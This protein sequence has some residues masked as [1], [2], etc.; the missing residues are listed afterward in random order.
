MPP[1]SVQNDLCLNLLPIPLFAPHNYIPLP[2]FPPVPPPMTG[3][4]AACHAFEIPVT[5]WWPPGYAL[6]GAAFTT[7]VFHKM[8]QICL[9][10]HDCGKFIVHVQGSPAP[11]NTLTLI[12]IPTSKRAANFSSST[13]K[14]NGKGVAAMTMISWPPCPM[15]YCAEPLS[16]PLADAPTSHLN[17]VKFGVT[18]ADWIFGAIAIAAD[19]IIEWAFMKAGGGPQKDLLKKA[20]EMALKSQVGKSV[21]QLVAKPLLGEIAKPDAK[22]AVKQAVGFAT[23]AARAES[24]GEGS[25][26]ISYEIGGPFFGLKG[27]VGYKTSKDKGRELTAGAKGTALTGSAEVNEGGASIANN[28]P[29]GLGNESHSHEW[30][31]GT[32][33]ERTSIDPSNG[34]R[35]TNVKTTPDGQTARASSAPSSVPLANA[36]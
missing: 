28:H 32:T 16:L 1:V 13:V 17:T 2:P 6:G 36:L 5:A 25:A 31:K 23:G 19:M 7:T 21:F 34:F 26:S 15:T 18:L 22:W 8:M 3:T 9:E 12:H 27:S 35:N 14:L 33:H 20:E 29:L 10:G 30:G 4:V 24:T 11:N